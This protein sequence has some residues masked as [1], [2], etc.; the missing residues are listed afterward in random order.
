MRLAMFWPSG[1]KTLRLG[2]FQSILLLNENRPP[3]QAD[4]SRWPHHSGVCES[5]W[6]I[7]K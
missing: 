3:G 1:K 6:V 7:L 4:K 5:H 2:N